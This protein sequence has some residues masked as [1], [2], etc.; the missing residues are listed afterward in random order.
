MLQSRLTNI[1]ENIAEVISL[2]DEV[3]AEVLFGM[4]LVPWQK[5]LQLHVV[6]WSHRVF[7]FFLFCLFRATPGAYGSSQARGESEL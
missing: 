3:W 1:I 7:F 4:R 6:T 5:K 2:V